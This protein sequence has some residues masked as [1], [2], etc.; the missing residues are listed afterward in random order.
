MNKKT[1]IQL[2]YKLVHLTDTT[3]VHY[4]QALKVYSQTI[5]YDQ[6]T[7]TS[8]ITYWINHIDDF[9]DCVPLFFALTLNNKVI[10]YAELAYIICNRILAID[11]IILD[12]QYKSSSAFFAF[13]SLIIHYIDSLEYD[14]D[15][16]TKEI[17]CEYTQTKMHEVD[18]KKYELE[19]FKVANCLYMHPQLEVGNIESRKEALLMIYQ[20]DVLNIN[21]KKE[22]YLAIVD[23]IY[24]K[25]YEV[26]D[27]P[28][29]NSTDEEMQNHMSLVRNK[30]IIEENINADSILLN[31]YPITVSSNR[32]LIPENQPQKSINRSLFYVSCVLAF[33]FITLFFAKELSVEITSIAVVAIAIVFVVL[34]FVALSDSKA[35]KIIEQLPVFSK[36]FALLK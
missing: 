27:K 5:S 2:N 26:W 7:N 18:I 29:W 23:A 32:S 12:N 8:E 22:T 15:F 14:Y 1:D 35:A 10:G 20:K 36:I 3:S 4:H 21:L 16:I 6:K 11:Y 33:T 28:F 30:A 17:L 34:V 25:Y 24:F 31:G 9:P 13:Y 19:N